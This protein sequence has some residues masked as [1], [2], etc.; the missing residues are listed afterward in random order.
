MQNEDAWVNV[1]RGVGEVIVFAHADDIGIFEF[2]V[3]QR[4]GISAIAI[5]G[6]PTLIGSSG[7][8]TRRS[9]QVRRDCEKTEKT[10]AGQGVMSG[11]FIHKVFSTPRTTS[12]EP[13][14]AR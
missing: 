11:N 7:K 2:F 13:E 10:E 14:A 3:E 8:I 9:H 6:S 4:I 1:H 12:S 5:V